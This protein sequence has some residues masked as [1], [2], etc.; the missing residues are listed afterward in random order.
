MQLLLNSPLVSVSR[1]TKPHRNRQLCRINWHRFDAF[2]PI[3][4][5]QKKILS[6]YPGSVSQMS[7][8]ACPARHCFYIA[9][10]Q[11]NEAAT[12]FFQLEY[13]LVLFTKHR[14]SFLI[15]VHI[16]PV[17]AEQHRQTKWRILLASLKLQSTYSMHISC[18]WFVTYETLS[19]WSPLKS[20]A[21][22]TR[23]RDYIFS[24]SHSYFS[25][26]L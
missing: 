15:I 12:C 1:A 23:W 2:V 10:L 21:E 17:G 11:R 18:F 4:D 26:H 8:C 24:P 22:V 5:S 25:I 7:K 20:S 6:E 13:W 9:Y 19:V 3:N 14:W 16:F